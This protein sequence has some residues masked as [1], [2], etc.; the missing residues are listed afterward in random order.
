MTSERDTRPIP[1]RTRADILW[2]EVAGLSDSL[3][4]LLV[5]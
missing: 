3:G 4:A 1:S 2:T 5:G